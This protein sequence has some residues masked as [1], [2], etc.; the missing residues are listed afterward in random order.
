MERDRGAPEHRLT[1]LAQIGEKLTH[2]L[3]L[4]RSPE[5][6]LGHK[7][8]RSHAEEATA[9]LGDFID[10]DLSARALFEATAGVLRSRS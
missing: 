1:E 9:R 3:E 7:A 10:E 2:A 6:S 8:A 4:G 5:S